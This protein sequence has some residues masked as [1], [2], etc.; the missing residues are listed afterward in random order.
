MK[1]LR[2]SQAAEYRQARKLC[3]RRASQQQSGCSYA[4]PHKFH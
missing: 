1:H 3:G 2:R 4:L